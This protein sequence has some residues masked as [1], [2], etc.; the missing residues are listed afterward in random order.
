MNQ[1]LLLRL[2]TRAPVDPTTEVMVESEIQ[3][4]ASYRLGNVGNS[5]ELSP[6]SSRLNLCRVTSLGILLQISEIELDTI[7]PGVLTELSDYPFGLWE[8]EPTSHFI[9][10]FFGL[11]RELNFLVF[12]A[13]TLKLMVLNLISFLWHS[14]ENDDDDDDD[15]DSGSKKLL[16]AS[17]LKVSKDVHAQRWNLSFPMRL[18][19]MIM[20]W[21]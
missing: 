2:Q 10:N 4:P 11:K 3:L 13:S 8:H 9:E 15:A 19:R 7:N 21:S 14:V 16:N 6:Y 18:F 17:I 20:C 5:G 12:S 1:E